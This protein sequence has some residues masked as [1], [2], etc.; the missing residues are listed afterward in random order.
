MRLAVPD[1]HLPEIRLTEVPEGYEL[2]CLT[3]ET[4]W[5]PVLQ[6]V[7][8]SLADDYG[9]L[10]FL[11][12]FVTPDGHDALRIHIAEQSFSEG[13]RFELATNALDRRRGAS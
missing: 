7:L 9:A 11:E 13:R 1:L 6:G 5:I 4:F 12:R 2:H 3:T 8:R 10:V